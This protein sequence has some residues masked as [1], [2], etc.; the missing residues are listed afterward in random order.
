MEHRKFERRLGELVAELT[1]S[2][3]EGVPNRLAGMA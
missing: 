3:H 2:M 1:R